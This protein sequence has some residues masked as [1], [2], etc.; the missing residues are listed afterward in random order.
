LNDLPTDIPSLVRI[1]Q[2]LIVHT[3]WA[4]RY[5]LTL[6]EER[7]Q[8]I[9]LRFISKILGHVVE[10]DNRPL[11]HARAFD[12][13]FVGNCRD[14]S[15][16]L[17]AILRHQG[18][19]ARAR[20]G[21]GTYFTPD[22]YEDHWACEYWNM[23]QQRWVM[24]DAQLD[25]L[26]RETL[27]IQFDPLDVPPDQFITGGKAWQLCRSGAVNPDSFG[28][29]EWHGRWF[30]QGDL[31]RDFLALNKIELLPWDGWGLMAGPE[32]T[33]SESE[34]TLLDRIAALTLEADGAFDDIRALYASDARLHTAPE[35]LP[36][37]T[38]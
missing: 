24:V 26:Q 29:L 19:S 11:I 5:G 2:G 10:L 9:N 35:W 31:I 32:D 37:V 30:V 6:S 7:K 16:L 15:T 13:K 17:C 8:D 22:H 27:N 3:F 28:I 23:L 20:C 34:L 12:K 33:V 4:E 36:S 1:V 38:E 18:V 14:H 21:F 25:Q